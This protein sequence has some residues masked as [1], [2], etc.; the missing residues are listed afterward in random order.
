LLLNPT[1]DDHTFQLPEPALPSHIFIDTARP[2]ADVLD[3]KEQKVLVRAHS[4]VLVYSNLRP[5]SQ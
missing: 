5:A 3:L 1:G 4:A 2:E